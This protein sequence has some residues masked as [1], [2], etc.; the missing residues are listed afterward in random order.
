MWKPSFAAASVPSQGMSN[1][2]TSKKTEING[3]GTAASMKDEKK[4][5]KKSPPDQVRKMEKRRVCLAPEFDGLQ[6][7]E[8]FVSS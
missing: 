6:C 1:E 3:Q 4:D 8:T 5:S 7:F 2:A